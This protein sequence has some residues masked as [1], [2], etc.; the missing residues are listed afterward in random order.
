[1]IL[2]HVTTRR[3]AHVGF[4]FSCYQPDK[5]LALVRVTWKEETKE[6]HISTLLRGWSEVANVVAKL[7]KALVPDFDDFPQTDPNRPDGVNYWSE[8]ERRGY[9]LSSVDISH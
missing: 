8:L 3:G 5:K 4:I 1:M 7:L 9:R 6:V 2:E